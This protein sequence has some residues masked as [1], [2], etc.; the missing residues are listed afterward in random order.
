[1]NLAAVASLF[2]RC[3]NSLQHP[4]LQALQQDPPLP[5]LL[6]LMP[7]LAVIY[8]LLLCILQCDGFCPQVK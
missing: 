7:T 4:H 3:P 2:D 8:S 1:V 6:I 5:K